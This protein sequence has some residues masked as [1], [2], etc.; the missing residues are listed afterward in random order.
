[1]FS[2][3]VLLLLNFTSP[4]PV[5]PG[6][7]GA[8][9]NVATALTRHEALVSAIAGAGEGAVTVGAGRVDAAVGQGVHRQNT[10]NAAHPNLQLGG[11]L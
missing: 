11:K 6:A 3:V 10:V 8:L 1:M 9:I 2:I 4:Y 7:V 5:V